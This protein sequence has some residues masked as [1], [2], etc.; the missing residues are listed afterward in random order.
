MDPRSFLEDWLA[1]SILRPTT[2]H[3]YR[4]EV[5]SWL[6]W[7]E[8]NTVDP[9]TVG[10]EHIARWSDERYLR[11][12]LG[13]LPFDGPEALAHLAEE[14]PDVARA[15]DKRITAITQYYTAAA[16][17]N[18]IR[19]APDL[20]MLRSGVDRDAMPP[21]RLTPMERAVLLTC[22]GMWGEHQARNYLRD[23]LI[24]YLLLEGLRPAEVTRVDMR[25]LYDLP[26]GTW[27]IRAPDD[28]ENVGKK[29]IL[30]PLTAAALKMYL[31]KRP[32]PTEGVHALILGQGGRPIVS[33]YPNMLIRQIS[34]T[35]PL[36]A[37]RQPPVTADTI[38]HT[39]FWD[40]PQT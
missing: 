17:R 4:L 25:H 19:A 39:G 30:E 8:A 28:F 9:Y 34:S 33:R 22:I 3:T 18:V 20:T 37:E 40:T 2:Q 26:D 13:T 32:R 6:D 16:D 5:T 15:H 14:R 10:I 38:A 7:C 12:H 1:G 36:L 31:P 21:K 23:R 29:F 24:A 11:P 27:E 35:H